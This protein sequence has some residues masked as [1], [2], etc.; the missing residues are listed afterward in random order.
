MVK[1]RQTDQTDHAA[2]GLIGRPAS[3]PTGPG[4]VDTYRADVLDRITGDQARGPL[5][6]PASAGTGVLWVGS[7][8]AAGKA[9]SKRK[10]L[11]MKVRIIEYPA[12]KILTNAVQRS[13][14]KRVQKELDRL[15]GELKNVKARFSVKW[16]Q[17][18]SLQ[19]EKLVPEVLLVYVIDSSQ[20]V[21]DQAIRIAETGLSRSA[22]KPSVIQEHYQKEG[23]FNIKPVNGLVSLSFCSV[24]KIPKNPGFT[25]ADQIFADMVLHEI[26]HAMDAEHGDGGV[27]RRS[28]VY[29]SAVEAKYSKKSVPKID[30]FLDRL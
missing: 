30:A 18:K 26:G 12:Q 11:N 3:G 28:Q 6:G 8:N 17:P 22:V 14:V 25:A 5:D 20:K 29:P 2:G 19:L 27:M 7:S 15:A 1:S 21:M 9:T 4:L 10:R 13:V 16:D 23:G 24:G